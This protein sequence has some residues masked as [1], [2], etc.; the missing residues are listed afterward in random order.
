VGGAGVVGIA[1]GGI[2]GVLTASAASQQKS[3]CSSSTN[4]SNRGQAASEHSVGS[5]DSTVSTVAFIAGG[6][7][8]VTGAVLFFTAKRDHQTTGFVVAPTAG[9][10]TAGMLL[11]GEF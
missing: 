5:T 1:V 2:F 7:L 10:H 8:L 3:D 4:C 11:R 6:A 9:T